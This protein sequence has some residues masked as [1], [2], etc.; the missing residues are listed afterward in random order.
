LFTEKAIKD[1][2]G[3]MTPE[4]ATKSLY[5]GVSSW[6]EGQANCGK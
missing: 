6:N 5:E 3:Q 2:L 1:I 4:E